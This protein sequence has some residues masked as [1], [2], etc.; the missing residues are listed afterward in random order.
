MGE[1]ESGREYTAMIWN[2]DG[3]W[4]PIGCVGPLLQARDH[5]AAW[6]RGRPNANYAIGFRDVPDWTVPEFDD[7]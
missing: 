5:L 3:K 1:S 4:E 6:K 7:F 2:L